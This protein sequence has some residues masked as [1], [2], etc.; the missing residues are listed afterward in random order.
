[1]FEFHENLT[2]GNVPNI[3]KLANGSD[4]QPVVCIWE[5]FLN[6]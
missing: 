5:V 3:A 6:F 2:F 1:V 4:E